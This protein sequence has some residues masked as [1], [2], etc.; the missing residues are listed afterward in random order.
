MA[1]K[2]TKKA[3]AEE[4]KAKS[5]YLRGVITESGLWIRRK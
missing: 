3:E 4:L 5:V 2:T 1:A